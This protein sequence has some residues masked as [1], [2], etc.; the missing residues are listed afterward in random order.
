M[1]CVTHNK[2][3]IQVQRD[4]KASKYL[5]SP[6]MIPP[7]STEQNPKV[8]ARNKKL[9]KRCMPLTGHD[10]KVIPEWNEVCNSIY[11][12]L[13]QSIQSNAFVYL[14]VLCCC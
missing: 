1:Y 4:A 11:Y 6:Y 12:Y 14:Y 3:I 10:V 13:F 2:V 7:E 5:V 8:R 9:K